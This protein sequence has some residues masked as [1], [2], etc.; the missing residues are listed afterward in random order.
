MAE[1][2]EASCEYLSDEEFAALDAAVTAAENPVDAA[3]LNMPDIE[4]AN[5]PC[6]QVREGS[7]S[8]DAPQRLIRN[9]WAEYLVLSQQGPRLNQVRGRGILW[10]TDLCSAEWCGMQVTYQVRRM[11]DGC[12][13]A[14]GG[15][16]AG[17][18]PGAP[19]GR[20]LQLCTVY[21][22]EAMLGGS[23]PRRRQTYTGR[24][25]H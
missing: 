2:L 9:S 20:R 7:G 10:V 13:G 22:G 23:L 8:I 17:R 5:Q 25:A 14:H 16:H 12:M 1:D 15:C 21:M 4:D 11:G 3:A 24:A 6:H 19:H 18:I